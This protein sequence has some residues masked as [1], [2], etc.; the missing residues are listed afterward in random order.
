[1]IVGRS[2]ESVPSASSAGGVGRASSTQSYIC[3]PTAHCW[4]GATV[5]VTRRTVVDVV[6]AAAEVGVET[7][8]VGEPVTTVVAVVVVAVPVRRWIADGAA[9]WDLWAKRASAAATKMR[10][11]SAASALTS[12]RGERTGPQVTGA[13][14]ATLSTS[15]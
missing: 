5:V 1:M 8:V 11:D 10:A 12:R 15:S 9:A 3:V 6:G 4:G 13:G 14:Q 2:R 7:T